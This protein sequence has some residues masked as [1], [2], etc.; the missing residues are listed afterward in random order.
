[1]LEWKLFSINSHTTT[2]VYIQA[3][4]QE[5]NTFYIAWT[6]RAL[7]SFFHAHKGYKANFHNRECCQV[8]HKTEESDIM[9]M[10]FR[11]DGERWKINCLCDDDDDENK[12]GA[13]KCVYGRKISTLC[14]F[15]FSTY[16]I[17]PQSS[18]SISSHFSLS[19]HIWYE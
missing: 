9:Q 3:L 17:Y 16:L 14:M 6:C 12:K 7:Y 15:I 4:E 8:K 11:V 10:I 18:F 2:A 19:L 13:L 1:M 5:L